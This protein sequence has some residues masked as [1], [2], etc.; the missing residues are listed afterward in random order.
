MIYQIHYGLSFTGR[1]TAMTYVEAD[2]YAQ[3][4]AKG[5][6]NACGREVVQRAYEL[7]NPSTKQQ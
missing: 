5:N 3:A 2:S 4:F 1:T 7:P 6:A